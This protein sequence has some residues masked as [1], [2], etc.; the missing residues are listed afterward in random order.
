V[1]DTV[2]VVV[3]VEVSDGR[4]GETVGERI[5]WLSV[6][7]R[8]EGVTDAVPCRVRDDSGHVGDAVAPSHGSTDTRMMP[9]PAAPASHVK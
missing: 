1:R 9:V 3:A 8:R 5:D 7:V 6:A 4:V 2:L